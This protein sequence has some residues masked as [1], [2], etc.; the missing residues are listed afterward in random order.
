MTDY[1]SYPNTLIEK[2]NF[3]CAMSEKG[4]YELSLSH[5]KNCG[6]CITKESAP[7]EVFVIAGPVR[8]AVVTVLLKVE[9]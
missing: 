5:R 1:Q 3:S 7:A 6:R 9:C 8:H 2:M 4:R